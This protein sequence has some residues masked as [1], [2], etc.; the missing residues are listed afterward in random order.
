[1]MKT[2]SVPVSWGELIDK[3]TILEIK[4]K[5]I[6]REPAASNIN[7]ELSLLSKIAKEVL[8]DEVF[9]TL[10]TD[11][12]LVNSEL[13]DIEDQIRL[14]ESMK[15]FGDEFVSLAR[16]IYQKNDLRAKLKRSLNEKLASGLMEEKSYRQ[17]W[18]SIWGLFF[19]EV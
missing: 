10:K 11:L 2:P 16:S 4:S 7:T 9:Q 1:M 18:H 6:I 15:Q 19:L 8:Q 14:K 5:K 3:I 17:Y 12:F 13:W